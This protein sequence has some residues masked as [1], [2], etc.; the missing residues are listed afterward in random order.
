MAVRTLRGRRLLQVCRV[1][2]VAAVTGAL[3]HQLSFGFL[4]SASL[5]L[6]QELLRLQEDSG[7][8]TAPT[9]VAVPG[10]LV[11]GVPGVVLGSLEALARWVRLFPRVLGDGAGVLPRLPEEKQQRSRLLIPTVLTSIIYPTL[12]C[13]SEILTCLRCEV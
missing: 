5:L 11:A 9:R 3:L 13:F 1:A 12:G 6:P 4:L 7:V 8:D 10:A 2:L